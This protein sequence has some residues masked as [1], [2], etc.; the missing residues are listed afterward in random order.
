V[1]RSGRGCRASCREPRA[2]EGGELVPGGR[3][4]RGNGDGGGPGGWREGSTA[5]G[6]GDVVDLVKRAR[7]NGRMEGERGKVLRREGDEPTG[8]PDHPFVVGTSPALLGTDN[9]F[10]T[11]PWLP[12]RPRTPPTKRPLRDQSNQRTGTGRHHTTSLCPLTPFNSVLLDSKG[13]LQTSL[14]LCRKE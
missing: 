8:K 2:R 4:R 14:S 12:P 9:T 6:A 7:R 11:V 5:R 10:T 13:D 3:G 1:T